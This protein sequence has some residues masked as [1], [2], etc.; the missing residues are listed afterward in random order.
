LHALLD[1]E[2]I[3]D[4]LGHPVVGNPFESYVIE[5]IITHMPRWESYFYHDSAGN[6]IDLLLVRGNHKIVIE[7]TSSTAPKAEKGFWNSLK[8]VNPDEVWV[9]GNV[10]LT[11][12]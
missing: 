2:L 8:V 10:D 3:N 12:P 1:T 6:E 11:Y 9:L 5:N 7:V 4:V